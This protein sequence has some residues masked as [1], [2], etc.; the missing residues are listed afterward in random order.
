MRA[1]FR[2][3]K[4]HAFNAAVFASTALS[5]LVRNTLRKLSCAPLSAGLTPSVQAAL[6]FAGHL[7]PILDK[8]RYMGKVFT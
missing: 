5:V 3:E 1:L 4:G 6:A 2:V 7:F 8:E